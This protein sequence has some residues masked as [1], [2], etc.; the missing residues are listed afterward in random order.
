LTTTIAPRTSGRPVGSTLIA[1]TL[2]CA[3]LHAQVSDERLREA[4]QEPEN[5]LTY[6]GTYSSNRYSELDQMAPSNIA[7]LEQRWVYQTE[8]IGPWQAT[9]LV[10]DAVMYVTQR[11]N[12]VVALDARTGRVFWIY[13]YPTPPDQ[14]ACCGSN[15][16]GVAILGDTLFLATLDAHLVAIDATTGGELWNTK[17]ADKDAAY[18]LTL[19]P[20]AVKDKVIVGTSGGDYGIRGFIAAF[21]ASTGEEAWRFYTIPGPGEPGH[22]TWESCPETPTTFCDPDAWQHGGGAVW[23]T[24]SYD[25]TLNLTYWGVGNPGPDFNAAQRPGDNL[26]SDS[27]VALDA[28]TGELKWYFQFTPDDPY[29]YDAVQIP[30]LVDVVRNGVPFK[31]MLWGNRNGFFYV[32]DRETGRFLSGRPFV[33]LNWAEGLDDTGHPIETPQPPGAPTFPGVQGGTNWYSPSYSPRTELFY[34]TAWENYGSVFDD[35]P[36]E[37]REGRSFVGGAP[38]SFAPAPGAPTVPGLSRGPLNTWTEAA[39]HGAVIA[40]DALTG[41]Q[42]WKFEMTDVSSSGLLTTASDLL[43]S[44]SREGYFQALDARTGELLW[45]AS[46]GG[47]IINGPITYEVAGTQYVATIAGHSLVAFALRD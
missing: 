12:D 4:A 44:G 35:A 32:L 19:A 33:E 13:R 9:P 34:V 46:L 3:G 30:V 45:K 25:P 14:R 26:Y 40:V 23:L 2:L 21:D 1:A 43:F 5:W 36:Q 31:V 8:R 41:E 22:E 18:A 47:Q 37:Y 24:G 11:P 27:V 39:G 10:V 16:R 29:D 6:S 42:R 15:N 17:V 38:T 20:L 28:D 7:N